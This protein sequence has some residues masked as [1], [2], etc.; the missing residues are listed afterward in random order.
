MM[1]QVDMVVTLCDPDNAACPIPPAGVQHVNWIIPGWNKF[2]SNRQEGLR[3]LR[4]AIKD[5]TRQL[6]ND[7]IT[8]PGP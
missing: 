5:H 1:R 4:D 8:P 6:I 7:L 2:S 3:A